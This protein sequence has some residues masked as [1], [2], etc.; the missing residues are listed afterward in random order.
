[1]SS[2]MRRFHEPVP[3]QRLHADRCYYATKAPETLEQHRVGASATSSDC[4][5]QPCRA[6]T[7]HKNLQH[8]SRL[9]CETAKIV[10]VCVCVCVCARARDEQRLHQTALQGQSQPQE[11]ALRSRQKAR[12]LSEPA[13]IDK[14]PVCSVCAKSSE[15]SCVATSNT[16]TRLTLESMARAASSP[17]WPQA[18]PI[19]D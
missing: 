1:M 6:R 12:L 19:H 11:P 17:V 16:N 5:R 4:S 18:T 10:C 7:N 3:P 2:D 13:K 9:L 15:L 14:E 8:E